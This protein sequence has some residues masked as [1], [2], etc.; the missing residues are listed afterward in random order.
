MR[1]IAVLILGL[2]WAPAPGTLLCARA[3]TNRFRFKLPQ[4][5]VFTLDQS[6]E[7]GQ[8]LTL[9]SA[10]GSGAQWLP[11]RSPAGAPVEFGD[12]MVVQLIPSESRGGADGRQLL[13]NLLTGTTL[14][15]D[16]VFAVD[17]FILQAPS[18]GTALEQ[19]SILARHP[20]VRASYPILRRPRVLN[21]PYAPYPNDPYFPSQWYLENRNSQGARLGPDLNVRAAWPITRGG[22]ILVG[23]A[24]DGIDVTHPELR[25]R[26]FGSP[27]FNF[28][29]AKTNVNALGSAQ[30]H[31]TSVAG[32]LA[33]EGENG[34]GIQGVASAA[35]LASWIIFGA[36]DSIVSD[37]KLADMF[38]FRA[39][40]VS[41][42]NHSWG[43]AGL[44]QTGPSLLEDLAISN[45]VTA[46]RGGRG[47]VIVRAGG[48]G[49]DRGGS[50]T[51]DGYPN[52]PRVIAVGAVRS[53][54][55][56]T[57]YSN[58]GAILLV[59]APSG[60]LDVELPAGGRTN[61]PTLFTTDRPGA[62][63]YNTLS[64]TNDLAEYAF[65][66]NGFSGTSGSTPQI[67]GVAALILGANT[68]LSYR[69]VQQILVLSARHFDLADPDMTT[70]GAGLRVSHNQGYGIPDAGEAVRL[71]RPWSNRP[72]WT[73]VTVAW[74]G[75]A[76]VPDDG[77]RLLV[78]GPDLRASLSSIAYTPGQGLQ[79]DPPS[80]SLAVV[81]VGL[82][83]NA[84]TEDVRGKAALIQRG[85]NFFFEKIQRAAD[86]G[87]ALAIV[88]NNVN[89]TELI[90]MD[91]T[92]FSPIPAIFIGQDDGELLRDYLPGHPE[93][94]VQ[95]LVY[96]N[97][98]FTVPETLLCEHVGVTVTADHSRR[99]DL[100]M[101]L[102]S[103]QG[104]RSILQRV[105]GDPAEGPS[106]W[107]YWSTHH[108]F[109][110]SAGVWT[111]YASDERVNDRGNITELK[112]HIRGVPIHDENHNG[113]A[114]EW[115]LAHFGELGH[116]PKGDED[117]DGFNNAR[118]Q[119]LN[120][121][122]LAADIP[123]NIDLALWNTNYARLSWP[124]SPA[125]R[126]QVYSGANA[127]APLVLVTNLPAEFPVTEFFTPI[128]NITQRFF[129]I[130]AV[131]IHA[132]P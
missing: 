67:S 64:Y 71:A 53:D 112:L 127:A 66:E 27:H 18:P 2:V 98:S 115:E 129:Q 70:N 51:D 60:D 88:Y 82:A 9:L 16:R 24:D 75:S 47:I 80:P 8:P 45:A 25:R 116:S 1:L 72:P 94:R 132:V 39:N 6:D 121:N 97:I 117:Q 63:G 22:G 119:L 10:A 20:L 69:D 11:G 86:A 65:D 21:G 38:E 48:N 105:N 12:R 19:A 110:S 14:R 101:T 35:Q 50:T 26:L 79:P 76:R 46:G 55:R 37:E 81:H 15:L 77:R 54:G 109:E 102:V 23:V 126:Y 5:A 42:Q 57:S 30:I 114:D 36:D 34:R 120:T 90:T 84:I 59:A 96:T 28:F 62:E 49:R 44:E 32:I 118:E 108:F 74:K 124:G 89:S 103:P 17:T 95:M 58:P 3:A 123:F 113:L 40:R 104:T 106:E 56:V 131:P 130:Q 73:N 91:A 61:F 93:A 7:T 92:E 125:Y 128:T 41:V 99:G 87:A 83:T 107:T 31:A 78:S 100:R 122:P 4:E 52:D 85:I 68:N 43:N 111:F 13:Q 33:G 29:T